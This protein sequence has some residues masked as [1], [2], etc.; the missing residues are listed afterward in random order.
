MEVS[1]RASNVSQPAPLPPVPTRWSGRR[2]DAAIDVSRETRISLL[3][4][5]LTLLASGFFFTDVGIAF[6]RASVGGSLQRL[7]MLVLFTA[8]ALFM[9]YGSFV[10]QLARV[11]Y[12]RRTR[13]HQ[14]APRP[15]TDALY[16]GEPP[17]LA[18]LV[19][20]YKEER[21]VILQTLMSAAL[22]ECPRRRVVLLIDNPPRATEPGDWPLL[23]AARA[24]PQEVAELLAPPAAKMRQASAMFAER[25]RWAPFNAEHE[26]MVLAKLCDEAAAWFEHQAE[27][28][29][30]VD[31]SDAL[32]VEQ[33][34][35][36]HARTRRADA[37][38]MR[39]DAPPDLAAARRLYGR[40][41]GLFDVKL[42]SFERK[43]FVNLSHESNKAMNLNSYLGLMGGAFC[44]V[45]RADG[46]HLEPA[47]D[48]VPDVTCPGAE[49]VITLDADS[50]LTPDY[51]ATLIALMRQP[52][53]ERLAVAQT[54]YSA[55]PGAPSELER[56]A[57]ATTDLQY[58]VHQG[59]AHHGATFWVG[60]NALIRT[61]A[62]ADLEQEEVER[63]FKVKRY[64]QDR[65]VIE[66]TESTIDL[67]KKGWAL[68]SYPERLS[69]SATPPD[70][71][72]LLIQ[73]RRWAN[74]GLIILGKL[75]GYLWGALGR[76]ATFGEALMRNHYLTS[77][78]GTNLGLLI[79]LGFPLDAQL[80]SIW[81]PVTAVPYFVVYARDLVQAGY[82]VADVVRV[83]ALNLLL[84][85]VNLGGV[86]KSLQQLV[87]RQKIPF[88]RTPKQLNRTAVPALYLVAIVA[89]LVHWTMG[90]AVDLV[91]GR[92]AHGAFGALNA[93]LLTYAVDRFIGGAELLADLRAAWQRRAGQA[94]G[95]F[96]ET[97]PSYRLARVSVRGSRRP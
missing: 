18:V 73:R 38:R 22:L 69:Y 87:T 76:R 33:V 16:D 14:A 57:G 48:R 89:L 84:V 86:L 85:P 81:L 37:T 77:I 17:S 97:A 90:A 43:R 67:V 96:E 9:L 29:P 41:V 94:L 11:G 54:P 58:I 30:V 66:D 24:L 32:F 70:F 56:I 53:N 92:W 75:L 3:L 34:L 12:L 74:G 27:V 7:G 78:A 63:G 61:A 49:F 60:A 20:S 82:R 65:T 15:S 50:V 23:K 88:G 6:H 62:L 44:A 25:Q 5:L 72:S 51:A 19:P 83:Y 42:E 40:L 8:I 35:R 47:G 91:A 31:H 36:A 21:R 45:E 2:S 79:L 64:I 71:G 46:L 68:T 52:G 39:A 93:A 28:Y 55:V 59:F 10:Y 26:A 1:A 4:L 13:A 80:Q 95:D